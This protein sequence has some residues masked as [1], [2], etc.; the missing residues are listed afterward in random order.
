MQE[1]NESEVEESV[2][3]PTKKAVKKDQVYSAQYISDLREES[4]NERLK[5]K[6]KEALLE[7]TKRELEEKLSSERVS[8]QEELSKA[9]QDKLTAKLET[10]AVAAGIRDLD[11]IKLVDSSLIKVGEDGSIRG[12]NEAIEALKETKPFLFGEEKKS[13]STAN[14]TSP[15]PSK[16]AVLDFSSMSAQD[17]KNYRNSAVSRRGVTAEHY[18]KYY[19]EK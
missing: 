7:S 15:K 17:F 2:V 12:I 18:E 6:E 3:E 8:Y 16:N 14:P 13:S 1:I 5:A 10:A 11:L 4:K 19:K 9:R